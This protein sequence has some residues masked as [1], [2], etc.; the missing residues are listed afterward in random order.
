[1][2]GGLEINYLVFGKPFFFF[3]YTF[4]K[5]LSVCLNILSLPLFSCLFIYLFSGNPAVEAAPGA[6]IITIHF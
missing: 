1:M 5:A 4:C 6:V 3:T 2:C